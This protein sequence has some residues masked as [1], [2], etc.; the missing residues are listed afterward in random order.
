MPVIRWSQLPKAIGNRDLSLIL[1]K[2]PIHPRLSLGTF[3]GNVKIRYWLNRPAPGEARLSPLLLSSCPG[4][5]ACPEGSDGPCPV[6]V[7]PAAPPVPRGDEAPIMGVKTMAHS[8]SNRC[9][10]RFRLD[11]DRL[12]RLRFDQGQTRRAGAAAAAA[13]RSGVRPRARS[14]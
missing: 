9:H 2:L 13:P 4:R 7:T 12:A 11:A 5:L 6:V 8:V 3:V 10:T 1:F 14:Q